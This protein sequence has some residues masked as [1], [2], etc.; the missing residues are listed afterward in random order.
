MTSISKGASTTTVWGHRREASGVDSG[1]SVCGA[2][3][4]TWSRSGV[5][6]LSVH[7]GRRSG[8]HLF[9]FDF[10][11]AQES[12]EDMEAQLEASLPAFAKFFFFLKLNLASPPRKRSTTCLSTECFLS[13]GFVYISKQL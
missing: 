1:T 13:N 9:S 12:V 7:S 6:V 10:K 8:A 5:R 4:R 3:S 2:D 11:R